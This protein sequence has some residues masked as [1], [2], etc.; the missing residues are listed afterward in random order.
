[1]SGNF[2]KTAQGMLL[3]SLRCVDPMGASSLDWR[4]RLETPD[5]GNSVMSKMLWGMYEKES[6]WLGECMS[7]SLAG[8]NPALWYRSIPN[9][10]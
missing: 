10:R 6:L 7:N 5:E 3:V 2:G 8:R 4:R 1:M 9:S